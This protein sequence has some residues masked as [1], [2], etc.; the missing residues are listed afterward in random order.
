M[1]KRG[2]TPKQIKY[3]RERAAGKGYREAYTAAGYSDK[4]GPGTVTS[5]AYTMETKNTQILDRIKELQARADAGGIMT[6]QQRIQ[7]LTDFALDPGVKDTDR[8]RALDQLARMHSDYS[9][10]VNVTSTSAV[11]LSYADR[12]DAIKAALEHAD[13]TR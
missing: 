10:N 12:I 11:N 8:L 9:D 1:S 7:L 3:C 2:L 6:R 5:N 4:G 13:E